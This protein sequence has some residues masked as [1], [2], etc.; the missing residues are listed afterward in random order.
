MVKDMY[1]YFAIYTN[2]EL[3]CCIHEANVML[4]VSYIS[5]LKEFKKSH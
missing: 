4:Y 1:D 2:I 3:L 5:V